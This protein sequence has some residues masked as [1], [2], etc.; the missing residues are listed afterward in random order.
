M[1]LVK[2]YLVNVCYLLFRR[3]IFIYRDINYKFFFSLLISL[4][5][6]FMSDFRIFR[7]VMI[8]LKKLTC[9]SFGWY[10][11]NMVFVLVIFF[12]IFGVIFNV[13][14]GMKRKKLLF[15]S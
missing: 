4:I 11:I 3:A 9:F 2:F 14:V 8:I 13:K 7:F 15:D 12:L 5:I 6:K 1:Y 10:L